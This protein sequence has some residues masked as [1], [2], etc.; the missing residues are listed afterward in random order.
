MENIFLDG[1]LQENDESALYFVQVGEVEIFINV[2]E[3]SRPEV[4][5]AYLK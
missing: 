3:S 5:L 2:P 4:V 1:A